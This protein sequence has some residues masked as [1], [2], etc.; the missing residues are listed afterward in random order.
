MKTGQQQHRDKD[1]Y[2]RPYGK[3]EHLGCQARMNMSHNQP[4]TIG[5]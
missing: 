5:L 1:E 3:I 2:G 4:P